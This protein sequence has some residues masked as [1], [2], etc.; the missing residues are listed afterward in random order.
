MLQ[1]VVRGSSPPPPTPTGLLLMRAVA[2]KLP[3]HQLGVVER[4]QKIDSVH[5]SRLCMDEELLSR[6]AALDFLRASSSFGNLV[7]SLKGS[8]D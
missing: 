8:E 3:R 4:V 1:C 2:G 6:L 5:T 7:E